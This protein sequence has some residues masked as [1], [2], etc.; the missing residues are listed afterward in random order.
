MPFAAP[1]RNRP[2]TTR[3]A[4]PGPPTLSDRPPP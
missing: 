1:A 2:P 4:N 3:G